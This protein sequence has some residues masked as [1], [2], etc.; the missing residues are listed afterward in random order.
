MLPNT[1]F[2]GKGIQTNIIAM[3]IKIKYTR[4]PLRS[5]IVTN[6]A[7]YYIKLASES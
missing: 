1:M 7:L 5:S 2:T 6:V 3:L 4:I